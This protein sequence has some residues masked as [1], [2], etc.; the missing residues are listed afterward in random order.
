MRKARVSLAG[1]PLVYMSGHPRAGQAVE[2]EI[3]VPCRARLTLEGA[4]IR[5]VCSAEV[6]EDGTV[7]MTVLDRSRRP[8]PA[9]FGLTV[10]EG[11]LLDGL[12]RIIAQDILRRRDVA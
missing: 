11:E 5:I 4:G 6:S 9:D 12:A 3:P 8:D 7:R 1:V 2:F 10:L